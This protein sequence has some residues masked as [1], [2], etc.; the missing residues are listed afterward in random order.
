MVG[1]MNLNRL[2]LVPPCCDSFHIDG[3][4]DRARGN[5]LHATMLCSENVCPGQHRGRV[6]SSLAPTASEKLEIEILGVRGW[7]TKLSPNAPTASVASKR[8]SSVMIDG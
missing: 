6:Q 3:T 7:A 1:S 4:G 2:T 5:N 8:G